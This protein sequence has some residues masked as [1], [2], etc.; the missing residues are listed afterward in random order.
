MN[1]NDIFSKSLKSN[2]FLLDLIE[3]LKNI[4][5]RLNNGEIV[6]CVYNEKLV[7]GNAIDDSIEKIWINS[8]KLKY[9]RENFNCLGMEAKLEETQYVR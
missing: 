8:K 5:T 1:F 2:L 7:I 4:E 6:P 9:L 3:N